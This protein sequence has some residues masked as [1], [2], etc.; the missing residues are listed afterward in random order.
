LILL[1][2]WH[3]TGVHE[4][5][6]TI[7]R[8]SNRWV[9]TKPDGRSCDPWVSDQNLAQHLDVA[10][11]RQRQHAQTDHVASVDSFQHPDARIIRPGW[12]GEPF[13][14]HAC[15]RALFTIKLPKPTA[16]LDQ[17]AA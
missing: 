14:L 6:V 1:C 4:G 9:F 8:D 2:Q 16:D 3:H 15:V 7:T 12:T 11:R 10:L 13:D 17:Q 5:G